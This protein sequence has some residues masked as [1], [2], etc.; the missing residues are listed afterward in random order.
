MD[1]TRMAE[2]NLHAEHS[3]THLV[4]GRAPRR[5]SARCGGG[6]LARRSASRRLAAVDRT[7]T[8]NGARV[9][10]T[11]GVLRDGHGRVGGADAI[12]A[13]SQRQRMT[14][15]ELL[16]LLESDPEFAG[17][18]EAMDGLSGIAAAGDVDPVLARQFVYGRLVMEGLGVDFSRTGTRDEHAER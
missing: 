18:E 3:T 16:N 11:R 17:V 15:L 13:A 14:A 7:R 10:D 6:Q 9:A 4:E 12:V 8:E 1:G 5:A 2:K